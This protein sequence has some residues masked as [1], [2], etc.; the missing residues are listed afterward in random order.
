MKGLKE[1]KVLLAPI[2]ALTFYLGVGSMMTLPTAGCS[3]VT[4]AP[5]TLSAQATTAWYGTRVIRVMDLLRDTAI[6]AAKTKPKP[7]VSHQTMI[8]VVT[9]HRT[10]IDIVHA[11]PLG[12]Q[13]AVL[14]AL[15]GLKN[16]VQ[17]EDKPMLAMYIA[18]V[19]NTLREVGV[20]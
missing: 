12:W 1:L 14:A 20:Q 15:D 6:D 13:R 18:L 8:Q 10:A 4:K 5:P 9:W 2:L 11:S 7:L 3:A 19:E 17:A 16:Q